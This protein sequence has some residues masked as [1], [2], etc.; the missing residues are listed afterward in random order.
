[1]KIGRNKFKILHLS[2]KLKTRICVLWSLWTRC[3]SVCRENDVG[4][5]WTL[6]WE[7]A[8]LCWW[9]I[10]GRA[11][12]PLGRAR[13]QQCCLLGEHWSDTD[14]QRVGATA[15]IGPDTG[16]AP[17]EERFKEWRLWIWEVTSSGFRILRD[18]KWCCLYSLS[19]HLTAYLAHFISVYGGKCWKEVRLTQHAE[20]EPDMEGLEHGFQHDDRTV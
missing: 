20:L 4:F 12:L 6:C 13:C 2:L 18:Q 9:C 15:K 19:H 17:V 8:G 16:A 11:P 10:H 14:A 7:P 3:G 1:M 5:R